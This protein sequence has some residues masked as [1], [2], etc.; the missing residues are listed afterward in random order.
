MGVVDAKPTCGHVDLA[1]ESAECP[2]TATD[3]AGG[4]DVD[5]VIDRV[6]V[7]RRIVI[8]LVVLDVRTG[9]AVLSGS[10]DGVVDDRCRLA[11]RSSSFGN[12]QVISRLND[13]RVAAG[14]QSNF[15]AA[16]NMDVH[17][18]ITACLLADVCPVYTLSDART[19]S[20]ALSEAMGLNLT[21]T[22]PQT[23]DTYLMDDAVA[24][25]H[26]TSESMDALVS[27]LSSISTTRTGKAC[28]DGRTLRTAVLQMFGGTC[29]GWLSHI[30][31]CSEAFS[32]IIL[33]IPH[34]QKPDI[35]SI[36]AAWSVAKKISNGPELRAIVLQYKSYFF[37]TGAG[38]VFPS[39]RLKQDCF[40]ELA[41]TE[42]RYRKIVSFGL[43]ESM[44]I[45]T[46]LRNSI[47]VLDKAVTLRAR[48]MDN[49]M[50]YA[51]NGPSV[52]VLK[53]LLGDAES[54]FASLEKD[55]LEV[56]HDR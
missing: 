47:S 7:G 10:H 31:G 13:L 26:L 35:L 39:C 19:D 56:K 11:V 2:A 52:R 4:V 38:G 33:P 48:N 29:T 34:N 40:D 24:Q 8:D 42:M 30:V 36:R 43:D 20:Q 44:Y 5:I 41:T 27:Q 9:G 45:A 32:R 55:L 28:Y 50:K 37:C 21:E 25:L 49:L 46:G 1:N 54:E 14:R 3:G 23:A 12:L 22:T 16:T 51:D 15:N 18:L 17:G 53:Y 6:H